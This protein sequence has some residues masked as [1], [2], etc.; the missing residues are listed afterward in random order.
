MATHVVNLTVS[1]WNLNM[2][3][4]K[5]CCSLL[6]AIQYLIRY[7]IDPTSLRCVVFR[8]KMPYIYYSSSE[9]HDMIYPFTDYSSQWDTWHDLSLF[10]LQQPV[11]YMTWYIPILI[12]AASEIHDMIFPIL[13]TAANEIHDMIYLYTDYSSQWDTWHDISLYWLQQPVRY[14]TWYIPI[15]ITAASEIHDMIYPYQWTALKWIAKHT[16]MVAIF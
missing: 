5:P 2:I 7:G 15:L 6:L 1:L 14:M 8:G 9:I 12:T 11:R 13:N 3:E 16:I 10:W 4:V